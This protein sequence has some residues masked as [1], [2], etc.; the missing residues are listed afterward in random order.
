MTNNHLTVA[1]VTQVCEAPTYIMSGQTRLSGHSWCT[2]VTL[3]VFGEGGGGRKCGE[4]CGGDRR[5]DVCMCVCVCVGGMWK[6]VWCLC[7]VCTH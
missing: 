4:V 3:C 5:R 6:S 7:S 2:L 1:T